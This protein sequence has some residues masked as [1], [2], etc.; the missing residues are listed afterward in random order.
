MGKVMGIQ[1]SISR[2]V[3]EKQMAKMVEKSHFD[4]SKKE[5][6]HSGILWKSSKSE[7]GD[8]HGGWKNG[9]NMKKPISAVAVAA[10]ALLG[11]YVVLKNRKSSQLRAVV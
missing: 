2:K 1:Q 6:G 9:S 3:T 7:D 11:L 5:K 8:I 4:R 10:P